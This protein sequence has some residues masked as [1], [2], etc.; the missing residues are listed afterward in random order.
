MPSYRMRDLGGLDTP[1]LL[2]AM[3]ISLSGFMSYI[4]GESWISAPESREREESLSG[5]CFDY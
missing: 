1:A 5:D 3:F 2:I 4:R